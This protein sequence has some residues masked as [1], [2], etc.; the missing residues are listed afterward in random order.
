MHGTGVGKSEC[1]TV[2]PLFTLLNIMKSFNLLLC[3]YICRQIS[4]CSNKTEEN[5]LDNVSV[6]K[7]FKRE[8]SQNEHTI[9]S[10]KK[11]DKVHAITDAEEYETRGRQTILTAKF[12]NENK[13]CYALYHIIHLTITYMQRIS[14]NLCFI[15]NIGSSYS[16][17]K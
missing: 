16:Y 6:R 13:V 12:I 8:V 17:I 7:H 1:C 9:S 3:Y 14:F 2:I 4:G 10:E 15:Y 5:F 11:Y